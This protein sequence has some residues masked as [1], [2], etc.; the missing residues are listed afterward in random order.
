VTVGFY[1]P[2]PPAKTGVADYA[3]ALLAELKRLGGVEV[4]P[5]RCDVP[6]YHIGNN[7]LHAE[8][9]R[10]ALERPGVVVLHD[11]VLNHF[12]LG[13]LGENGYIQEFVHNYGEWACGLARELWQGRA[14]SGADQRYF[15]YPLLKRLAETARAVVVHNAAAEDAVRRHAPHA[16]IERIP[17]LFAAPELPAEAERL[18]YRQKLGIPTGAFLF[19]V[20]GYLRESKR[21]MTVLEAFREL[22]AELRGTALL[23]AGDF[24]STDLERA[25]GPLLCGP[26]IVRRPHLPEPEFRLAAATVD[27]CIS[28]RWPL[29]GETSGITIRLMGIG[30]P[31]F[32]TDSPECSKFP[33]DA[34]IRIPHGLAERE[35]LLRHMVLLP[36]MA[37]VAS[38]IG[39]RGAGHIRAHH[40]VDRIAKLYWGLLCDCHV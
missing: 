21:L 17:H 13:Q 20:F 24:V 7:A 26:G 40:R 32:V 8:I 11:A 14:A 37:E 27:A 4:A 31:V 6:L 23:V 5:A 15:Q 9:Y 36:S 3:A 34:C 12:L 33:E 38:A 25:A 16:R 22:H 35:S 19:G 28:L 18:R 29:T 1:S 30:K 10:R 2:L 39:E